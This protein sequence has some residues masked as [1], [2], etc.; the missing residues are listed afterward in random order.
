MAKQFLTPID[1]TGLEILNVRLQN[2][3]TGFEPV[4]TEGKIFWNSTSK[5]LGIHDG[6]QWTYP[7]VIANLDSVPDSATRLAFLPAERTKLA[8]CATGSTANSTD[9]FLLARANHTGTQSA[10]TIV[11]GTINHAFTAG[12]DTKLAGIAVGATA[13]S[14]D[15][16]L[17]DRTT[18]TGITDVPGGGTGRATS[19]T[20]FGLIAAGTTATGAHQTLTNGVSG[21]ILKSTGAALPTWQTGV[22]SDVGLGNVDNTSDVNKPVSTAQATAIGLKVNSALL[23]AVSGVATLDATTKVPLAQIPLVDV[24][25][26]GTGVAT[27]TTAFGLLTAG[28]TATGAVQ[29]TAP[30]TAG[31]LLKSGGVAAVPVFAAGVKADVGLANVDNTA[32]TAKPISTAQQTALNLLAPLA[33]P[34]FTGVVAGITKAMVGLGSVDNTTDVGKPISTAAQTAMNLLAP[35]ANPTFTGTVN[36]V[37]KAMVGLGSVDNTSD[38]AK[39]V[40]TAQAAADTAA[41]ARANHT[42]TQS[43]DTVINGV[44]NHVFTAIMDTKLAGVATGATANST[45]A[46]LLNRANHTGTQVAA[47]ISDFTTAV[48]TNRLDQL[49]VPTLAVA[50]N[51]QKMTG[52]ADPTQPQDSATKAYVDAT[53]VGLDVKP[54][55]RVATTAN[56]TLSAPQ[57]VDTVAVIA[58]DRVLVKNQTIGTQNGIYVVAAG[59]WTR[60][61]D[62]N[63]SAL[64]SPGAFVFTEEGTQSD[65]GWTLITNA[66]ITLDTTA[67]TFTQFSG[68]GAWTAGDGMTQ[69]ATTFNVVAGNGILVAPDSV[70]INSAVVVSKFAATV[71]GSTSIAVTHS[72]GTKDITYSVRMVADDSFVEC[73]AVSTSINV[74]TLGFAV[75]PGAASLRVVVQA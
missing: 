41:M 29:T 47:T 57:T 73:D 34:T 4:G 48:R 50:M 24:A 16:Q 51:G 5:K 12:D 68:A 71:G 19:T 27:L 21:Q 39:P 54:S 62:F 20:P 67:L 9:A 37:T 70:S 6:T 44:T 3:G 25:H 13:N 1:L 40:S 11:D 56:V 26:G 30:G 7:S 61:I 10:D 33:S 66:P 14:T 35:L 2:L 32:D 28:T 49:A 8:S 36:G 69:T 46:T 59:A 23:G 65:S 15:A 45:D 22:S 38:V 53:S 31:W 42:G 74:L 72:L 75:A 58:G 60:A 18:H 43:A 17:R 52:M 64:A 63:T 55:V